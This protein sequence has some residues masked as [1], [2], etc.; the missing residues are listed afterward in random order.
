MNKQC[1]GF[2]F[3]MTLNIIFIIT[4]LLLTCLQQ[5]LLYSKAINSQEKEHQNFYQLEAIAMQLAQTQGLVAS[6]CFK[7]KEAP[8]S[9]ID[10]LVHNQG[11]S[12][13]ADHVSYQYF[14]E[15]LG[16]FPCLVS[17]HEGVKY[18][19]RHSRVTL[20]QLSDEA[21]LPAAVLQIRYIKADNAW[22]CQGAEHQVSEGIS[23]WRYFPDFLSMNE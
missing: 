1:G 23:S 22:G 17:E 4:L 7:N 12:L 6:S 3:L 8:N 16:T 13:T 18:A 9:I 15:D 2:I 21:H 5:V 10:K 20:L 19:T 14:V 11:C